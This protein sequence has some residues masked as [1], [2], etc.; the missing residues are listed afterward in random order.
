[1]DGFAGNIELPWFQGSKH[2]PCFYAPT[3]HAHTAYRSGFSSARTH[4]GY[5]AGFNSA[6]AVLKAGP[7]YPG[8]TGMVT[9]ADI[10]GGVMVCAD[11]RGLPPYRPAGGDSAPVGPFGFHIHEMGMCEVGDPEKPF[12]GCGGHW[13]PTNQPHGN[14]AGD[15]PVLV[16]NNGWARMCFI[17][18][19][20]VV[21]DILGRS[22][23]IHENPDDYRSQPS[24]N[25]GKRIAC[26]SIK[27]WNSF[28]F[29]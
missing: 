21:D 19:R 7:D 13:N 9:F 27:P 8:I 20:F 12:E 29:T 16:A 14:H 1:M 5:P 4:A 22:V 24:G 10:P 2:I 28:A 17:T 23:M 26:G 18:D 6:Y 25:S 15:F 3:N 11:V